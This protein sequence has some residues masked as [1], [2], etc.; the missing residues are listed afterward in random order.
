MRKVKLQMQLSIDG[1]IA[2]PASEMDWMVWDW[3]D[4]LK[5][6]VLSLTHSADTIL[7]GRNMTD[8]FVNYWTDVVE[9][10]PDSPEFPFAKKMVD[11]PKVVFSKTLEQSTWYNTTLATGDLADE[12]MALKK[13]SGNDIILYGGATLVADFIRHGLIDEYHLF[14]N[15]IALGSG[16]SIF[17]E[18]TPLR[19]VN[20]QVFGCGIVVLHYEPVAGN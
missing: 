2:G 17:T 11:T 6:Y 5:Q 19:L 13:Q 7:L 20:S 4:E 14:I 3:D 16:L 15:P 10:K 1:F 12:V 8:G 9:N 18:R